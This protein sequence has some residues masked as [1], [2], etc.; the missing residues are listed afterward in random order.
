MSTITLTLELPDA[1]AQMLTQMPLE[2]RHRFAVAAITHALE[3]GREDADA[4][5]R[6]Y[7]GMPAEERA[8]YDAEIDASLANID[9]GKVTPVET[10]HERIRRKYNV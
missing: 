1:L 4:A 3:E 6:W 2:T 5:Q 7:D 8:R 9:A 10:V